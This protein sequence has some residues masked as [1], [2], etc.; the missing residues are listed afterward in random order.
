MSVDEI[1]AYKRRDN[2]SGNDE[3]QLSNA[4]LKELMKIDPDFPLLRARCFHEIALNEGITLN[5]LA[6]KTG[7]AKSSISRIIA[8]LSSGRRYDKSAYDL[9][10]TI[11]HPTDS[12]SKQIYLTARG[13]AL[14]DGIKDAIER[15]KS[16]GNK[17]TG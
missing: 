17:K 15:K 7:I 8:G 4:I 1:Y 9:V 13:K 6:E 3:L 11:Q 16:D 14:I 10:K 12:R 2:V 5:E